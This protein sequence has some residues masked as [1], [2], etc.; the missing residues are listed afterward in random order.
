M[1]LDTELE[2]VWDSRHVPANAF[3]GAADDLIPWAKGAAPVNDVYRRFC[4]AV[5]HSG[6]KPR[7]PGPSIYVYM[8]VA[9]APPGITEVVYV[10]ITRNPYLRF[11]QHRKRLWWRRVTWATVGRM[12]CRNH[13]GPVCSAAELNE[14]ARTHETSI[15]EVFE[16]T[17][18]LA[19]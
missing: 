15:I 14:V 17:E 18:N 7:D 13:D 4:A 12:D 8:L 19:L 9:G 5:E 10:G 6:R 16:P 1:T 11:G 2:P 3:E